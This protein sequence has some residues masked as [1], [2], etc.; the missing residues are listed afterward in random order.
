M[1]AH[2]LL[3]SGTGFCLSA[4]KGPYALYPVFLESQSA[5][6]GLI[7]HSLFHTSEG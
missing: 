5:E 7:E 4:H 2:A 3:V 1:F 6:A